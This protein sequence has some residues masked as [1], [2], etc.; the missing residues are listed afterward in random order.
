VLNPLSGYLTLAE[1]LCRRREAARAWNFGP[2]AG[3]VRSV[4]WI[5]ERLAVL[6]GEGLSWE[7]DDDT[8]PPEASHL[9]LDSSAAG[10]ELG[11]RPGWH[12][13]QALERIVDWHRAF[14]SGEDMRRVSLTQIEQFPAEL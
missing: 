11:W 8:N 7:P 12:L 9:A 3:D 6:W 10:R 5:V 13:E 1:H 4:Q 2:A 14:G